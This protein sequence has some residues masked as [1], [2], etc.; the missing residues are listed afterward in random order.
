[1]LK[2]RQSFSVLK[3]F[4]IRRVSLITLKRGS[5]FSR[6]LKIRLIISWHA[7]R[8]GV[9]GLVVSMAAC[10]LAHGMSR[11]PA[12]MQNNNLRKAKSRSL[13]QPRQLGKASIFNAV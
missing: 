11:D 7:S 12:F 13:L 1:M 6:N 4:S 8:H 2:Q 5:L 3:S 10:G 9:F